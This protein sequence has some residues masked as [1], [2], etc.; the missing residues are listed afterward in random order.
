LTKSGIMVGL[1]EE[2]EEVRNTVEQ[3][4]AAGADILTVGQYLRPSPEHLPVLRYYTPG[5][6]DE[7]KR[8]A[9]SLGYPHVESGPLVRSSYHADEQVLVDIRK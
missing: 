1:G 6:F 8:Y 2:W 9:L 7:I 3:I 5:E 4:R